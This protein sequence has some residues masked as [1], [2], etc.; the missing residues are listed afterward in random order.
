VEEVDERRIEMNYAMFTITKENNPGNRLSPCELYQTAL[1]QCD[2]PYLVYSH[3]DVTTHERWLDLAKDLVY[4]TATH[5]YLSRS[6]PSDGPVVIGL[7]GA[8][9]LGT[10]DIYK[11]PYGLHQMS[12]I[13]YMSNQDDAE[14][15]GKRI[16]HPKQIAVPEAFFMV[17]DVKWLKSNRW[18]GW[19]VGYLTHHCLDTWIACQ[20]ARDGRSIWMTGTSCL[21]TGGG[22][23]DVGNYA[24]APWLQ[25][26]TMQT[27]HREP[28]RWLYEEYRD[29][30]PIR[31]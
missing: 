15:H 31:V 4:S 17:V 25:G 29:V 9:G 1:E 22:V 6:V 30:L 23:K 7:S 19:P 11:R 14:T 12:R 5:F 8:T 2:F 3:N 20:A 10:D 16:K 26:G 18:G 21:H 24:T 27:D 13:N 28:H